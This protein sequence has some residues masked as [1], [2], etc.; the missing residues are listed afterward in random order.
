MGR[1]GTRLRGGLVVL[2]VLLTVLGGRLLQLQGVDPGGY[3]STAEGQRVVTSELVATRGSITD[4]SGEALAMSIDGRAVYGEPRVIARAAEV[5]ARVAAE[6]EATVVQ[7]AATVKTGPAEPTVPAEPPKPCTPAEIAAVV[8]PTLGLPVAELTEKLSRPTAFVYLARDLDPSVGTAVRELGLTGVGVL[9]E[10]RREHPGG[11]L[12]ASVLGFTDREGKGAGGIEL[13]FDRMLAGVDGTERREVD[14]AGRTIPTAEQTRTEA[15]PG[16]EVQLTIDRD[17]QWYA[18]QVL[19]QKVAET[20]ADNGSV[21]VMD[22]KTGEVLAMATAPTFDAD[23]PGAVPAERRGNPAVSDI[24]DP[25]SVNKIIIAAAALEAGI[26]EPDTVMSVPYQQKFG[27][28]LVTDS[29]QHPV[30]NYTFNGVIIQSSNVGTVQVAAKLGPQRI[31]DAMRSFG[32]AEKTGLRLPGEQAGLLPAPADWSGS[33]L[34]TIPIGQGV[35]V[36]A[37]QVASVYQTVANGGVRVAPSLIRAT[38]DPQGASTPA[39]KPETRRVISEEVAAAV[40]PM[41]EGVVSA[42][43]T[44]ETAAIP[45]YRIAGKTGTADR[46]VNGTYDGSYTSSF[47]GFAPADAPRFVTAVVL[48]GTGKKD[49]YGGSVAGPVFKQV[50]GFALQGQGVPPTG[51]PFVMPRVFADGRK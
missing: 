41:L 36:T 8:A 14:S 18:Q 32:Y 10:P 29:H 45:G 6:A 42:E 15:V 12:A 22:V 26:V 9:S 11:D 16:S 43:G 17:L 46:A 37:M 23:N 44:A 51:Q 47:V 21:I 3:A 50:M 39:P 19:A 7:A 30:E 4:R 24:Y 20:E 1:P 33:S 48:Q 13:E 34:G 25:G 5:C 40:R 49:Y 35:S 31:Y 2:L 27:A 38:V 28:K